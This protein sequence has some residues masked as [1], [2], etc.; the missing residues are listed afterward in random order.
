MFC[1]TPRD[2]KLV[3]R[4][5]L[6]EGYIARPPSIAFARQRMGCGVPIIEGAD[7]R[8][9]GGVRCP[10]PER[11]AKYPRTSIEWDCTDPG[12]PGNLRNG[13]HRQYGGTKGDSGDRSDRDLQVQAPGSVAVGLIRRASKSSPAAE[14]RK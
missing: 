11:H 12:A 14:I 1:S 10:R 7:H 2:S 9:R 3:L 6:D 8:H 13:R 5:R 4:A